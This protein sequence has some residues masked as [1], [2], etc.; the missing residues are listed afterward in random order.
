MATITETKDS[1]NTRG[2]LPTVLESL[3]HLRKNRVKGVRYRTRGGKMCIVVDDIGNIKYPCREGERYQSTYIAHLE[4]TTIS[5]NNIRVEPPQSEEE[6][7]E[8][9]VCA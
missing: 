6:Q 9:C 8:E 3:P 1:S 5:I 4:E 7:K 2:A